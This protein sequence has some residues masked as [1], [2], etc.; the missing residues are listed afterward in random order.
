[1]PQVDL[2]TYMS[3]VFF[4]SNLFLLGYVVCNLFLFVPVINSYKV[5]NRLIS[6]V[7]LRFFK[8][9]KYLNL[10]NFFLLGYNL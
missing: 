2:N 9:K 5:E 7:I 8:A 6:R 4:V 10:F 3:T 1:M